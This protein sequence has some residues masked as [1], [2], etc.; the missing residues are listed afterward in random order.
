[1]NATS[2]NSWSVFERLPQL[3]FKGIHRAA[4]MLFLLLVGMIAASAADDFFKSGVEAL[5]QKR[6]DQA[7]VLL[8][9][10][11]A[12]HPN[13]GAAYNDRGLAYFQTRQFDRAIA[14]FSVPCESNRIS[15]QHT[16]TARMRTRRKA[17]MK[18]QSLTSHGRSN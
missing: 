16:P 6:F 18:R 11:I 17:T 12:K 5:K 13:N 9:K 1:M 14:D 4:A 8:S 2:I 3:K 7:I 10:E 15:I